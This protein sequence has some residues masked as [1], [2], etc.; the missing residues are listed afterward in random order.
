MSRE[1]MIDYD[2]FVQAIQDFSPGF[3]KVNDFG[4]QHW[5]SV[6]EYSST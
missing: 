2:L 1:Q 5:E 3:D 4:W 6:R